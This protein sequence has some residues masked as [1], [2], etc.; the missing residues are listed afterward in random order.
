MGNGIEL[1]TAAGRQGKTKHVEISI[2]F[3]YTAEAKL[4]FKTDILGCF[5]TIAYVVGAVAKAIVGGDDIQ[6]L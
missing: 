3:D 5:E 4:V 2:A 1:K 6:V